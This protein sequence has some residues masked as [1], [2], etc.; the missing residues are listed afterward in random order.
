M[1]Y[2]RQ[3]TAS[4]E[5][6]LGYFVDSTDGNTEETALTIANT[7]IKIW[8]AGAT[9]LASKNSGG[10]THISNGLYSAVFD[11]IDTATLGSMTIFVHVA[12]ALTARVDALVLEA[13]IYDS[14][15]LGD[16]GASTLVFSAPVS[17]SRTLIANL[18]LGHIGIGRVLTDLET[19]TTENGET[20]RLFFDNELENTLRDFK[21]PFATKIATLGLVE[22][23]PT[24][25]WAYSYRYPSDCLEV[26]RVLSGSRN[27]SRQSRVPYIITRDSTGLLIYT[28]AADAEIEY[29]MTETDATRYPPDFIKALS[30]RL[31][32]YI[33][34]RLTAGDP[35]KLGERAMRLYAYELSKAQSNAA[36]EEQPDE[37]PES[38]FT[39]GRA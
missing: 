2:L 9:T 31:A 37:P 5:V 22:E 38:E 8:R 12:G 11:D 6:V 17:A 19:D 28:D 39:R 24:T 1:I 14:F 30:L 21:W 29:T 23:T 16:A 36:N 34:P 26:R 35:F 13:S 32:A 18:A 10:A 3:S 7:D 25:E 4:Q 15:V 27:D 33:A 20:C